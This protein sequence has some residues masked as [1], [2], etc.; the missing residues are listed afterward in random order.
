MKTTCETCG[1]V[2][3]PHKCHTDTPKKHRHKWEQD[4]IECPQCGLGEILICS[5]GDWKKPPQRKYKP[6]ELF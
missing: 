4:F 2:N 5:C 6:S 1:I 3:I